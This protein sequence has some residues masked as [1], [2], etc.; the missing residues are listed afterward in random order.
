MKR[1]KLLI[2]FLPV[3]I[4]FAWPSSVLADAKAL[5][6]VKDT[7]A[8]EV[9][10]DKVYGNY[11]HLIVSNKFTT[12]VVYIQFEDTDLPEGAIFDK[13][14]LNFYIS[15]VNYV[16]SAKV[17]IGLVTRTW[18]ET[19]I[20]WNHKPT[21]NQAQAIES[22]FSLTGTGG[23][24]IDVTPLVRQWLKGAENKGLFIYPYG[25][26]YGTTETEYAFTLKSKE[27]GT[28]RANIVV[29][30]HFEPTPTPE[31]TSIPT[32]KIITGQA[33]E[34]T[35]TPTPKESPTPALESGERT[36]FI[37]SLTLGQI[38]IIGLILLALLVAGVTVLVYSQRKSTKKP[39]KKS[40]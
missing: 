28:Q 2:F 38:I 36:G 25:F 37:F 4:L 17:N 20:T 7:Y 19:T 35:S 10:P 1:V 5:D 31:P 30:Y 13:A 15:D 12:R 39:K 16:D 23:R 34:I 3:I 18:G 24:E 21:I 14:I 33:E 29:R 26:L 6:T 11:D 8:N 22:A 9:Y 27:S 40:N 32:P